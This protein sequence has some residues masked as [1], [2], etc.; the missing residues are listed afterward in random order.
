MT[1]NPQR[2]HLP[3]NTQ[4]LTAF[5]HPFLVK[6]AEIRRVYKRQT[7]SEV[8]QNALESCVLTIEKTYIQY[9]HFEFV[10]NSIKENVKP[11]E[12]KLI[13]KRTKSLTVPRH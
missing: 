5:F 4:R 10:V 9:I 3:N 7:L 13:P 8:V 1:N 6:R 2:L 11:D 12:L